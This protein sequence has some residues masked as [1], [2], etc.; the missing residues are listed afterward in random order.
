[1]SRSPSPALDYI[2]SL[3]AA[4][5]SL[6]ER[7]D[8]KLKSLNLHIHVGAEEGKL[9]QVLMQLHGVKTA[10]EIGTLA[11]YSTIWMARALPEDG[12]IYTLNK[13]AAHI[14]M[15]R[16][17]F[18]Q[19]EVAERITML[20]GDAKDSLAKLEKDGVFEKAPLDMI[21]IDADK[22]SYNIYL[23]W[24]EKHVRKGGLIIADNTFLF[25]TVWLDSPRE[26]IAPTTWK[27]MRHFNERLADSTRYMSVMIPTREGITVAIKNF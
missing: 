21:F 7:I 16:E 5:D 27:T 10:L 23:D 1:M 11:G 25:D 19:V 9:L 2:R 22:I 17:H 6:L 24:A 3:Y 12:H 20:E 26:G 4:Q 8:N 18:E 15:A 13:E 14:A